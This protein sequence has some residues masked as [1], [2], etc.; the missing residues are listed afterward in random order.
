MP[1]LIDW[2]RISVHQALFI[3][4]VYQAILPANVLLTAVN[5]APVNAHLHCYIIN[6]I[7]VRVVC[8]LLGN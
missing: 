8:V 5:S 6:V 7:T 4:T 2:R 1:I 3:H